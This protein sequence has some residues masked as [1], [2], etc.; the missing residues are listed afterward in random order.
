[1]F[2]NLILNA[3]KFNESTP[4]EISITS[5][6]IS[7]EEA[8]KLGADPGN[9]NCI[10]IKD[11]GIGFE[12]EYK[13]KIFGIFQRLNGSNYQGTGIGLAICKKIADNHN[14]I[15]STESRINEGS[16]FSILLPEA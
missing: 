8:I 16:T 13:D 3:I 6:K 12:D 9:Y 14:G 5:E 7:A 2:Q 15:I 10:H 4:P 1:M 11:N